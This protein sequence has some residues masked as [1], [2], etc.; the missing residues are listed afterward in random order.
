MKLKLADIGQETLDII[1]LIRREHRKGADPRDLEALDMLEA[2][3]EKTLQ[4]IAERRRNLANA[5]R[6][7]DNPTHVAAA[8]APSAAPA[9]AQNKE[10]GAAVVAAAAVKRKRQAKT[11]AQAEAASSK[12][13]KRIPTFECLKKFWS[14]KEAAKASVPKVKDK[15]SYKLI[16]EVADSEEDDSSGE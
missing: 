15:A 9:M 7:K 6:R 13:R 5:R 2:H 16:A 1:D 12:G 3:A 10:A 4:I 8:P 14:D 11:E